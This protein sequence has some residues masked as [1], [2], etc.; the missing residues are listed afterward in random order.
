[1]LISRLV[2]NLPCQC[3]S[4]KKPCASVDIMLPK[5]GSLA[6]G[7][8]P[9]TNC[10]LATHSHWWPTGGVLSG[11][12]NWISGWGVQKNLMSGKRGVGDKKQNWCWGERI[13]LKHLCWKLYNFHCW[14]VD[15]LSEMKFQWWGVARKRPD[16]RPSPTMSFQILNGTAL[17]YSSCLTRQA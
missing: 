12:V 16:P 14:G 1:M 17:I 8:P 6:T 11:E 5:F 9:V 13:F 10:D 7:G 2:N 15:G 3:M 4:I